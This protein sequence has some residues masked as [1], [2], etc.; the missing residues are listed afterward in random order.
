MKKSNPLIISQDKLVYKES[1]RELG[2]FRF[3]VGGFVMFLA[4]FFIWI[5]MYLVGCI[6]IFIS[7]YLIGACSE[8]IIE[9]ESMALIKK[10]GLFYPFLTTKIKSIYGAES[11]FMDKVESR[12]RNFGQK[13]SSLSTSY[14]LFFMIKDKKI[15]IYSFDKKNEANNFAKE[16]SGFLNIELKGKT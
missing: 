6:L 14:R 3:V 15:H 11:L 2:A 4:V 9:K 12:H 10:F 5:E 8:L 7:L 13:M 1:M 16:V